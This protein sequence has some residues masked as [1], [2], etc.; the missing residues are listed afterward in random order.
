[1]TLINH[2]SKGVIK[3]KMNHYQLYLQFPSMKHLVIKREVM[4]VNDDDLEVVT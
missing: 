4:N 1:M 2:F 3:Y